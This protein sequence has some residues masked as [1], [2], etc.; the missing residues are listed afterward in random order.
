MRCAITFR[1]SGKRISKVERAAYDD[2]EDVFFQKNA[3]ADSEFCMAWAKRCFRK[4]LMP[5]EESVLCMDNL[6]GETTRKFKKYLKKHCN[7]LLW[8]S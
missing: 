4:G 5:M 2:R 3:R 1:G 6:H 7:T 8:L